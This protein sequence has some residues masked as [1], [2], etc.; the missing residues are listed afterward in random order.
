MAYGGVFMVLR[1]QNLLEI[2][3][4]EL[5]KNLPSRAPEKLHSDVTKPLGTLL[6]NHPR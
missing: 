1:W 2:C 5:G 6:Q 4:L 3:L